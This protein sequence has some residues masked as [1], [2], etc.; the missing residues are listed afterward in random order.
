VRYFDADARRPGLPDEVAA[1]VSSIDPAATVVTLINL[2]AVDSRSLIVQA[3]AFAEHDIATVSYT[4]AEPGWTGPDTEYL[5]HDIRGEEVTLE[6]N[7]PWLA[8]DLPAGTQV[9][10]TLR[11]NPSVNRPSYRNPWSDPADHLRAGGKD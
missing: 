8:V 7:G 10:L 11:L 3:G 9:T 6:G 5:H 2:A 4:T 1:L